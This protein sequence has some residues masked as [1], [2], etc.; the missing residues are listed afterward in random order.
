MTTTL[1]LMMVM[2]MPQAQ[3]VSEILQAR[4]RGNNA[5]VEE[6]LKSGVTL[7][8]FEAA[9][10]GPDRA[11]AGTARRESVAR[12]TPTR[13]M[14]SIHWAWRR[15]SATRPRWKRCCRRAPT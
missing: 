3:E 1:L 15:S 14:D 12:S 6:L 13:R 4:Y 2:A 11:R 8:I 7:N 10:T 5:R 9:A